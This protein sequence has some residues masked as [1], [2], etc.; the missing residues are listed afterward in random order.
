VYFP[1]SI[2]HNN[3][4]LPRRIIN[5]FPFNIEFDLL[6]VRLQEIGD[7]VDVF[8][9]LESNY[10]AYGRS[11]P[12]YL[13]DRLRNDSYAA[14]A[15]KIVHVFLDYFPVEA[16]SNGW[17]VDDLLRNYIVSKV[18]DWHVACYPT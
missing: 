11:K 12:L 17:I 2:R 15:K 6:D 8:L 18:M 3:N 14:Y 13:L 9:I 10:T 5:A 4:R 16:Y 7:V 1:P